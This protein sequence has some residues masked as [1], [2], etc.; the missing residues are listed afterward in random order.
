MY[1]YMNVYMYMCTCMYMYIYICIQERGLPRAAGVK[2]TE[3][4]KTAGSGTAAYEPPEGPM[5]AEGFGGNI[6]V[7]IFTHTLNIYMFI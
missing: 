1:M 6:C 5:S 7:C 4:V 3:V 2:V